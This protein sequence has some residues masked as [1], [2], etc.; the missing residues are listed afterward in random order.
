MNY[1]KSSKFDYNLIKIMNQVI[2]SGSL[3][4]AAENLELS[5]SAVSLSINKLQQHLGLEL[6]TRTAQ[7]MKPTSIATN[8]HES[9]SRAIGIIDDVVY[10]AKH[11]EH[12]MLTLKIMCSDLMENYYFQT[13]YQQRDFSDTLVSFT[14]LM[15]LN[16]DDCVKNLLQVSND[17]ILSNFPLTHNS[18]T[19]VEVDCDDEFVV[20]CSNSSLLAAQEFFTLYH[21]YTLPHAVYCH[22]EKQGRRSTF[23]CKVSSEYTGMIKVIYDSSSINGVITAV[24]SSEMISIFPRKVAEHFMQKRH[25]KLMMFP[26]PDEILYEKL[27]TYASFLTCSV[28]SQAVYNMVSS[29]R[30]VEIN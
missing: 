9:F 25:S 13:F 29:L 5:V 26:L 6:F 19:S 1:S 17:I 23:T 18:I 30:C 11:Q 3:S 2:V 8:I 24:E 7:G 15:I 16:H 14:N 27:V 28:K 4:R 12:A 10:T 20:V 21:Y 22:N